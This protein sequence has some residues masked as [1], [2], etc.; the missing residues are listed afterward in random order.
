MSMYKP[1]ATKI[2]KLCKQYREIVIMY[3]YRRRWWADR[4]LAAETKCETKCEA[5]RP[6]ALVSAAVGTMMNCR[7]TAAISIVMVRLDGSVGCT[8]ILA[9]FSLNQMW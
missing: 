6:N 8:A 7:Y 1:Y 9:P 4:L 2:H 3:M 5:Q